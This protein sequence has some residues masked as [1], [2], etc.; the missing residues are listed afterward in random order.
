MPFY[1]NIVKITHYEYKQ[2]P[3]PCQLSQLFYGETICG[4][5]T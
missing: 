1:K 2:I 4:L 3:Y 5:L